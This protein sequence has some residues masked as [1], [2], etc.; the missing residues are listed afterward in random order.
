MKPFPCHYRNQQR[1]RLALAYNVELSFL[2]LDT[3]LPHTYY[4]CLF[5]CAIP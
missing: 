4:I 2:V 3:A 1:D 5:V